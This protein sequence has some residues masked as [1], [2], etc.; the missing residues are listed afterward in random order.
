VPEPGRPADPAGRGPDVREPLT[1]G[2]PGG[3]EPV[4]PDQA[5]LG[6]AGLEPVTPGGLAGREPAQLVPAAGREPVYSAPAGLPPA[7]PPWRTVLA[8]T[9]RLWLQR[10]SARARR[11]VAVT[12]AVLVFAAGALTVLLARHASGPALAGQPAGQ[13]QQGRGNQQ[14]PGNLTAAAAAARRQAAAWVFAQVG[15]GSIVACDPVMCGALQA[16]GVPAPSLLVL[17]PAAGDPLGSAVVVSTAAVRSQFGARLA[18][19]YAPT[20]LASFGTGTALV[21]IRVIAPDG[22]AAYLTSLNADLR[23]RRAAGGLLL[24]NSHVSVTGAARQQLTA[25]QVDARLLI[26]LATLAHLDHVHVVGFGDGAR[27]SS[28]GV[29]LRGVELAS[30]VQAGGGA[31]AYLKSALAFV[32]A[33]RPP[34]LAASTALH[35]AA[36]EQLVLRIDYAAPSPLGLLAAH[37]Q[38]RH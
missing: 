3:I 9:L 33:Q 28:A 36:G 8:T 14:N 13:A 6:P 2:D 38:A 21:E 19:V 26:T 18:S 4:G 20:I 30:P 32:R 12:A 29:P 10:R 31:A 34:Y 22:A 37:D 24:R 7:A 16:Q 15:R 25:G 5:G 23:A 17:G 35:R 1:P 11:L 27:G